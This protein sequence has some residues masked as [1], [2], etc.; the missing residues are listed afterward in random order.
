MQRSQLAAEPLLAA[1]LPLAERLAELL[2]SRASANGAAIAAWRF[3]LGVGR[4]IGVGVKDGSLGGPYEPPSAA[5]GAR[6]GLH[7]HWSDGLISTS[8]IDQTTVTDF[9]E[10]RRGW[11]AHAYE[12]PEAPGVLPPPER[13]PAVVTH[14]SL[15]EQAVEQDPEPLFKELTAARDRLTGKGGWRVDADA[16]VSAGTRAVYSSSGLRVAYA[17][18]SASFSVSADDLYWRSFEKRRLPTSAEIDELIE[19]VAETMRVLGRTAEAPRGELPV[20]LSPGL[21]M[22]FI[23]RFLLGNL[24]ARGLMTGRSAFTLEDVRE[25]RK[26]A[27][28]TLTIVV[29]SLLD[30]ESAASPISGEGVPGGRAAIVERGRLVRPLADLKYAAMTGFPPT[31]VPGGSPGALVETSCE[32]VEAIRQGLEEGLELSSV[33]GMHGQDPTA[34]RYSLVA[35]QARVLRN[36]QPLGRARVLLAGSFLEHLLDPRTRFVRYPWGLNPGMVIWTRVEP[37]G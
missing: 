15:V 19:N 31:P 34:G 1:D 9:D 5:R 28:E 30:L 26:V 20:L 22:S 13:L 35:P 37:G 16:G 11:R 14:N 17:T 6:G 7:L 29:D 23:G 4:S 21:A 10:Q 36:G 33:L 18:T 27:S 25:G 3:D 12:D 8:S 24:G 32:P 2:D